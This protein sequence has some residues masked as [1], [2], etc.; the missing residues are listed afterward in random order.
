RLSVPA[1]GAAIGDELQLLEDPRITPAL[2]KELWDTGTVSDRVPD[3]RNAELRLV[4]PDGTVADTIALERPLAQIERARLYGSTAR[5]PFLIPVDY[6]AG[7]GSYNGPATFLIEPTEGHLN[8]LEARDHATRK[9]ERITLMRTLKSD[10]RFIPA[11]AGSG[12]EIL[13]A[14]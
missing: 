14:L 2:Q 4:R 8:F 6:G 13:Q 5:D 3:A 1:A 11:S 12:Q 9:S 10:W 7:A